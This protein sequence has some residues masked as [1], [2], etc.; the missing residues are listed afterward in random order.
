MEVE[1]KIWGERWVLRRDSTHEVSYL[2]VRKGYRCS[3]HKHQ[4]KYNLFVVLEGVLKVKVE[5]LGEIRETFIG[6]GQSFTTKPGQWHEFEGVGVDN[7]V[8]EEMYVEYDKNDIERF[9]L[10]GKAE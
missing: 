2:K 9:K 4:Q 8:I 5:E 6:E 3:W 10:G 7:K 1:L